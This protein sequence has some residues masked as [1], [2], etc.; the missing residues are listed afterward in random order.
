MALGAAISAT[1][2][3]AVLSY[4]ALRSRATGARLIEYVTSI[5]LA[6]P[7]VVYG[8]AVFWTFLLLPGINII[9]GTIWPLVISLTFIRLP[10]STRIIS[11]NL[12]QISDDLEEA[13]QVSGASFLRTFWRVL[14]PLMKPGLANSFAY[15]FVDSMRELGG[16]IILVTPGTLVYT[17][18]LL[19]F[20]ESHALVTSILSAG[21]VI[22]T[23]IIVAALIALHFFQRYWG[24]GES[25]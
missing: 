13:S 11:G 19:D 20:Y 24:G 1:L 8:L 7:G 22:L 9:Y 10:Y 2:I 3:G 17:T 25:R 6:F 18:L 4:A 15:I 12:V 21:S 16:V 5:P 14:A 23:A